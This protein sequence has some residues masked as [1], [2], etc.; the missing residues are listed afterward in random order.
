MIDDII[1]LHDEPGLHL[2]GPQFTEAYVE[3]ALQ[4]QR[5]LEYLFAEKKTIQERNGLTAEQ[6]VQQHFDE[7]TARAQIQDDAPHVHARLTNTG[8]PS[9]HTRCYTYYDHDAPA[10]HHN[11][12]YLKHTYGV[13]QQLIQIDITDDTGSHTYEHVTEQGASR[14]TMADTNAFP[15]P[16]DL[17][18]SVAHI[19]TDDTLHDIP[20]R[21]RTINNIVNE[22]Q[23]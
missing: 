19:L 15:H 11:H 7:A 4:L 3:Q 18:V 8:T 12:R 1:N 14:V 5:R 20:Q 9:L 23:R 2:T 22:A 16:S 21:I 6:Y 13:K 10:D 17:L